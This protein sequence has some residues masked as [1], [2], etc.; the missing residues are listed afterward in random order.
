MLGVHIC[1]V[2]QGTC[3]ID[4]MRV[5]VISLSGSP[6]SPS[7]SAFL[8]SVVHITHS[9]SHLLPILPPPHSRSHLSSPHTQAYMRSMTLND[10]YVW[11]LF[12][13]YQ[14]NW[15]LDN[16]IP[17]TSY[18][19]TICTSAQLEEI[20]ERAILIDHFPFVPPENRSM[21]TDTG[22]VS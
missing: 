14:D 20:L 19:Q 13:W 18:N 10:G 22:M 8:S 2:A 5:L 21:T 12:A 1:C 4:I 7:C 15:W 17:Q 6:L 3:S 11:L 9:C 16:P